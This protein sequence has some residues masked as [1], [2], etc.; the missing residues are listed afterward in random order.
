M[1]NAPVSTVNSQKSHNTAQT[2]FASFDAALRRRLD[3][4]RPR[5]GAPSCTNGC[6]NCCRRPVMASS[7][8]L[9]A[10]ID[11]IESG[12]EE[13]LVTFA[14]LVSDHVNRVRH[15]LVN[16]DGSPC[17]SAEAMQAIW[18]VGPCVFLQDQSCSIYTARPYACRAV[19]VWHDS[20]RC[21]RFV[22]KGTPAE[23]ILERNRV[24]WDTLEQ[25]ALAGRMPF[26]GQLT[27]GL[28]YLLRFRE[29]YLSGTEFSALID[30]LWWQTGIIQ[31]PYPDSRST[32]QD[33]LQTIRDMKK[34]DALEGSKEKPYGLIRAGGIP[35][36]EALIELE[37]LPDTGLLP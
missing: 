11:H 14:G 19:H 8:E 9:L 25:E 32:P 7:A 23:L 10:L 20:S 27:V 2:S 22:E 15:H 30:P 18:A 24:F 28:Y 4:W 31:F 12:G 6:A 21:D 29:L 34:Q 36:R 16:P 13:K 35:S 3:E 37:N 5:L 17:G 1:Q 26:Y 33:T